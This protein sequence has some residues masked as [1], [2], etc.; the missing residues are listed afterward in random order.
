MREKKLQYGFHYVNKYNMST[1]MT[2]INRLKRKDGSGSIEEVW[3]EEWNSDIDIVRY[4]VYGEK[5]V[6]DMSGMVFGAIQMLLQ[7]QATGIVKKEVNTH[8]EA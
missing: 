1:V 6:R 5:Q 8:A 3:A 4:S 7:L 2:F